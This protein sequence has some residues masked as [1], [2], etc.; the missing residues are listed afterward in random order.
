MMR[1]A[2]DILAGSQEES[3]KELYMPRASRKKEASSQKA[4]R[5]KAFLKGEV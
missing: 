4:Q 5:T 2:P 1:D 3:E